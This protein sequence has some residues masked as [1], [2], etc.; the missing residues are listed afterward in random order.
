MLPI[1]DLAQVCCPMGSAVMDTGT[2]C[3]SR[4]MELLFRDSRLCLLLHNWF[5]L[6]LLTACV[7]VMSSAS[8]LRNSCLLLF[9]YEQ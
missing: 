3:C 1:T 2:R 6:R 9:V 4:E 7:R 5:M 8:L